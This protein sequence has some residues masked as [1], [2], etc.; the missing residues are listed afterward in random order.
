MTI[1]EKHWFA[2]W[3]L[4]P[5][6]TITGGFVLLFFLITFSWYIYVS[7]SPLET[8]S[9]LVTHISKSFFI[10]FL[11]PEARGTI[12]KAIAPAHI[13]SSPVQ[14]IDFVINKFPYFFILIGII[15]LFK[16]YK[17]K[18]FDWEYG[19]MVAAS[20]FIVLLVI[21]V[22]RLAPAFEADRFYHVTLFYL[23]PVCILGGKAFFEFTLKPFARAHVKPSKNIMHVSASGLRPLCIFLAILFLF[24]VGFIQ[25]VFRDV[26]TSRSI[27]FMRMKTSNNNETKAIFYNG[28]T[29]EQDVFSA[30]WLSKMAGNNS[31][32]Y[33]DLVA[34]HQVLR[35]YGMIIVEREYYLS[36]D[37]TI[38]NGSYIYLQ[39][40]NVEGIFI[41]KERARAR[42]IEVIDLP[43]VINN[44]NKI[45][46]NGASEIYR[47]LPNDQ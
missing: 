20:A 46:S 17:Q 10:D 15:Y 16:N 3:N 45:Y 4:K 24:N 34:S 33:A 42:K 1:M 9:G 14:L 8:L 30:I 37:V 7:T 26:P 28:Y 35:G 22:P 18:E 36:S 27:S 19:L 40:L 29:P 23:A 21:V 6:K 5:R 44:A 25:E 47:S 2:K 31:K 11:N 12:S 39:S 38:E 43:Q 32:I 41:T 13:T